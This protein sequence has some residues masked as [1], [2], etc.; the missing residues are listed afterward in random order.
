MFCGKP[1]SLT[2]CNQYHHFRKHK[3]S[4]QFEITIE[5]FAHR[6]IFSAKVI[7]LWAS[8]KIYDILSENWRQT[9]QLNV[10]SLSM[11]IFSRGFTNIDKRNSRGVSSRTLLL[12][13]IW[14]DASLCKICCLISNSEEILEKFCKSWANVV[15]IQLILVILPFSSMSPFFGNFRL[16]I[17]NWAWPKVLVNLQQFQG[18][19]K[20]M[21]IQQLWVKSVTTKPY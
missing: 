20:C 13:S 15:V 16:L 5:T 1:S 3:C 10:E 4:I 18:D 11:L 9:R 6:H 7:S 14:C 19:P 21:I 2:I 17:P 12:I 8:S